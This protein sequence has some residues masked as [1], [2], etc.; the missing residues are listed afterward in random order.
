MKKINGLQYWFIFEIIYLFLKQSSYF[1]N[2]LRF[3]SKMEVM[4]KK[5][6][7]LIYSKVYNYLILTPVSAYTSNMAAFLTVE[8]ML[9][10]YFL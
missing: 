7:L 5:M 3:L 10:S 2:C 6:L 9:V 4:A 8:R 1:K